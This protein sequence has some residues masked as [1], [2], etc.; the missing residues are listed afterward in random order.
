MERLE[1]IPNNTELELIAIACLLA[2]KQD[3]INKLSED[4]FYNQKVKLFY[5]AIRTLSDNKQNIDIISVSDLVKSES[6]D[7]LTTLSNAFAAVPTTENINQY[8]QTLK[9]YTCRRVAIKKAMETIK[10]AGDCEFSTDIEFKSDIMQLFDSIP[11]SN[12]SKA[13]YS[14]SGIMTE[15]ME[16]IEQLYSG[17]GGKEY[18]TGYYDYDKI[19]A[20]FH[21]EEMTIIAARPGVGKTAFALQVAINMALK[22]IHT[23]IFSREMSRLQIAKRMLSNMA[24]IDGHKLRLC[25]GLTDEDLMAINKATREIADLPIEINDKADTIQEIRSYC[26]TL[27]TKGKLDL[28]IVDYLQL[29]Q[30]LTKSRNREQEVA[31]ISRSLKLMSLEFGIP[32]I[33]LSQLNRKAEEQN[34]PTLANLRESGSIEQDADNV[35]FLHVPKDTDETKD[36]FIIKVIIG[37]QRNGST[38]YAKLLYER[39][40]FRFFNM[41][42]GE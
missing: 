34:E 5:N 26:R 6:P 38:G 3:Y 1:R 10:I 11:V 41:T 7:A 23:A 32:V 27:A 36:S 18:I 13:D 31:E 24:V 40:T 30:T 9:L 37:K 4:D 20:G 22:G 28:L 14:M 17:E 2:D 29:V 8:I 33:V 21:P 19:T 16:N 15:V 39:K 12:A 25:K 42:K 35:V